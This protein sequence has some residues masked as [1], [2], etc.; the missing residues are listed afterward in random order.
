MYLRVLLPVLSLFAIVLVTDTEVVHYRVSFM[1]VR[2]LVVANTG[3]FA[4]HS[5]PRNASLMTVDYMRINGCGILNGGREWCVLKET[6]LH[7]V[8]L[9]EGLVLRRV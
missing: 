5:G 6:V 4:R 2:V 9:G 8:Y 3:W 7:R 1:L